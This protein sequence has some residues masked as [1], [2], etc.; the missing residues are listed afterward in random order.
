M[1]LSASATDTPSVSVLWADVS[2]INT[3]QPPRRRGLSLGPHSDLSALS[4]LS[5][6]GLP[7]PGLS[8]EELEPAAFAL[9]GSCG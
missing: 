5:A 8:S 3:Q 9:Q 4:K 2:G 1:V 7:L 6:T